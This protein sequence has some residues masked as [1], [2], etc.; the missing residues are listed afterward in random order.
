MELLSND[1]IQE[2]LKE[3]PNWEIVD[4]KWLERKFKFNHYLSGIDFVNELAKYAEEKIH[5]PVIIIDHTTVTL[6]I[7]SIEIGGLT[8][9]DVEMIKHF[10]Q[11]FKNQNKN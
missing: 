8:D 5:H 6:R 9:L 7:S 3:L 2:A 1:A 4:K 11:L 10:N